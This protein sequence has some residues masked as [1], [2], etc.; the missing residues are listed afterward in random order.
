M[1]D[2]NVKMGVSGVA[3]FKQGMKQ[4]QQSA[5]TLAAQM[6]ANESQYKATGDREQYLAEKSKLLKAQLEAQ[7]KAAKNAEQALDAMRK[8]GVEKTSAEYQKMEQALAG[9]KAAM[10]DA[11]A[12]MNG[13][14]TSE[15]KVSKGATEVTDSLNSI[16]KKV[17]L[18]AVVTGIDKITGAMEKAGK[19]AVEVGGQIWSNI[20]DS[21]EYADG[22]ATLAATTQTSIQTIEQMNYVAARFEAPAEM[23][24]KSWH[25]VRLNMASDSEEIAKGFEQLG[26]ATHEMT[27]GKYEWVKGEERDFQDVFWETGEAIMQLT[28]R[29]EQDRLATQLLGRNWEDLIPLFTAGRKAYE[30]AM[31]AAPVNTEKAVQ[32]MADLN[33]RINQLETQWQ[34]LKIEAI[35]AIAP[36]LEEAV[37][38]LQGIFDQIIAYLQSPDG[39]KAMEDIGNSISNLLDN[40]TS[41]EPSEIVEKFKQALQAIE[42]GLQWIEDNQTLVETALIVIGGGFAAVKIGEFALS[43]G[44]IVSGFETLWKGADKKLPQIPTIDGNGGGGGGTTGTQSVGTQTVTTQNVTNGTITSGTFSFTNGSTQTETVQTMYVQNMV[45]GPSTGPSINNNPVINDGS[46]GRTSLPYTQPIGLPSGGSTGLNGYTPILLPS[47][48]GAKIG[49]A[50]QKALPAGDISSGAEV[51]DMGDGTRIVVNSTSGASQVPDITIGADTIFFGGDLGLAGSFAISET[52]KPI[53]NQQAADLYLNELLKKYGL[54]MDNPEI[55]KAVEGAVYGYTGGEFDLTKPETYAKLMAGAK[56]GVITLPGDI[57]QQFAEIAKKYGSNPNG[58]FSMSQNRTLDEMKTGVDNWLQNTA[59]NVAVIG[60]K[61][62][63]EIKD[64]FDDTVEDVA[65]WGAKSVLEAKKNLVDPLEQSISDIFAKIYQ[66]KVQLTPA[67]DSKFG[68]FSPTSGGGTTTWFSRLVGTT[69]SMHANGLPY[70]P[71]DNYF[72]ILHRG[73]RVMTARENANYTYNSNNYFGAVNLHNG[74][75]IEALTESLNRRNRRQRAGYGA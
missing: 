62:A 67:G 31:E 23:M 14:Y 41:I 48:G 55:R 22:I 65:A 12:A 50:S 20:M 30:E 32:S 72:S 21:A 43:I 52:I 54:D 56:N 17:S 46:G 27:Y 63:M 59:V 69:S 33:D 18:D 16:A 42:E 71:H 28:D 7:K 60:A 11:Q 73:E 61:T 8:N 6:K 35:S 75:E 38:K 47:G 25:K 4:A 10:F 66:L 74:L 13:L 51:I 24:A 44:K 9:A 68:Y 64:G 49:G 1:A 70:V 58:H 37:K 5:K 15:T 39:Q 40:I 57:E 53:Q 3:Q 34:Y 26:V 29:A 19:K 45:G 36:A 2:V